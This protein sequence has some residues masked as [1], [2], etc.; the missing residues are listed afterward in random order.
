MQFWFVHKNLSPTFLTAALNSCLLNKIKTTSRYLIK[1]F[2]NTISHQYVALAFIYV[3]HNN[4]ITNHGMWHK[5]NKDWFKLIRLQHFSTSVV[6]RSLSQHECPQ[7]ACIAHALTL[8]I[9]AEMNPISS[10]S[11]KYYCYYSFGHE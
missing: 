3:L 8:K 9:H 5:G 1:N 11:C 4:A 7:C 2:F 10:A 6:Q